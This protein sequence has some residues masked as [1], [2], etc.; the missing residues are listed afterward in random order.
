VVVIPSV[1]GLS[2]ADASRRLTEADLMCAGSSERDSDVAIGVVLLTEPPEGESVPAG[3]EVDLVVSEDDTPTVIPGF[4]PD[5]SGFDFDT[6]AGILAKDGYTGIPQGAFSSRVD[7]DIV[8]G[9]VPRAGTALVE[10]ATVLVIFS[11]GPA[12]PDPP[13]HRDTVPK[14]K[15]A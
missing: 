1:V 15:K 5:V 4:V 2:V 3:T 8:I 14:T 13:T 12:P 7:V 10:G 9:T 6:A 11:R